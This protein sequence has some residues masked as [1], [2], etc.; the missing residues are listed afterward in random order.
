MGIAVGGVLALT[1][2]LMRTARKAGMRFRL[3][4]AS[5]PRVDKP[6]MVRAVFLNFVTSAAA[7]VVPLESLPYIL[8]I[9]FVLILADLMV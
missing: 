1:I 6:L 4:T 7:A 9:D 8:G 2:Y 3:F 5:V